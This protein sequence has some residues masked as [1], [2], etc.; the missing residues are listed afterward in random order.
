MDFSTFITNNLPLAIILGVILIVI[1]ALLVMVIKQHKSLKTLTNSENEVIDAIKGLEQK[2]TMA[3]DYAKGDLHR[4]SEQSQRT[5]ENFIEKLQGNQIKLGESFQAF[6]SQLQKELSGFKDGLQKDIFKLKE[7]IE[8]NQKESQAQLHEQFRRGIKDVREELTLN[9]KTH[10]ENFEKNMKGL[11]Q[12][13]DERLKEISG[14]VEKRLAD[15]FEKT[16]KTFQDVLKR[17]ALIDDAQKKITEL[18]SNVVSLQEILSD[19]RSRGAFGE[20]QLE[21]L[22]SNVMPTSHYQFQYG[23]E[24]GKIVDCALFLPEPT[25][26]I[27]VDAKFP[28]ENYQKMVDVELSK[29]ERDSAHRAFVQDIKK[30]VKDISEKYIIEGETATGAVMFIPA[31]AVFAEIHAHHPELVEFAQQNKVWMVSPTTMM[32]L[33]TTAS[34]VLKDEATRKQVHII[35]DELGKLSIEFGRFRERWTKL[36]RHIGQVTDDVKDINTTTKKITSRFTKIE[37]V[38]LDDDEDEDPIGIGHQS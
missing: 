1:L 34:A 38:D 24:N 11:T 21:S 18:S 33:L 32:A 8:T 15:G 2:Q 23:F 29:P 13:T 30:H 19:K 6:Q 31:E 7:Q 26:V 22:V 4:M 12:S 9:L 16:T 20:V 35:Q 27:G 10:G 36:S 25:G 3:F 5:S 28:L 17:L 37:Q 14:Q